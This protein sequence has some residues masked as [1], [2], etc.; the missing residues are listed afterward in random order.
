M[1]VQKFLL[2]QVDMGTVPNTMPKSSQG[3]EA[4]VKPKLWLNHEAEAETLT[5]W[6]HEAEAKA[7]KPRCLKHH[8][9]QLL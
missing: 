2:T 5:F 4:E 6:K 9:S 8:A 1:H 7:P 3:Y